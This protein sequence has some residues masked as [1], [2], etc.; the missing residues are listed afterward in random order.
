MK[1]ALILVSVLATVAQAAPV[2]ELV[3]DVEHSPVLERS[4]FTVE[5]RSIHPRAANLK[6]TVWPGNNCDNSGTTGTSITADGPSKGNFNPAQKS[7]KLVSLNS[8]YH[9]SFY[10]GLNQSPSGSP[11]LRLNSGNVGNCWNSN[12]GWLSEGLYTGN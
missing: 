8:G 3:I 5:D 1:Y 7:V 6:F 2:A 12:I 10:D 9:I 4:P 11:S